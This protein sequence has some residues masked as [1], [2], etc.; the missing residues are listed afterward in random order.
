MKEEMNRRISGNSGQHI[1]LTQV[2]IQN[3]FFLKWV[4]ILCF[5]SFKYVFE[6]Q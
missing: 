6:N 5:L 1:I 3:S 2:K 4:F